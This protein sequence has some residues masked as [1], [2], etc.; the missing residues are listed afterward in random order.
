MPGTWANS[1]A[2][3]VAPLLL[4]VSRS[5]MDMSLT[6]SDNGSRLRVAVTT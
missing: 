2:R 1:S 6:R 4:M 5:M 3:P